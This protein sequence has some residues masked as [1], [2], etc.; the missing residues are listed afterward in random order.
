MSEGRPGLMAAYLIRG[1]ASLGVWLD[2]CRASLPR[3]LT[4]AATLVL[5]SHR[6][7]HRLR[8]TACL[9]GQPGLLAGVRM[10]RPEELAHEILLRAG[11]ETD[12][13]LPKLRVV[14]LRGLLGGGVPLVYLTPLPDVRSYAE[15]IGRTIGDL[16][17]A[18][19]SPADLRAGA[20]AASAGITEDPV[21]SDRLRDI[22]ALWEAADRQLL[23]EDPRPR[24]PAGLLLAAAAELEREPAVAAPFG[25][26]FTLLPLQPTSG[27]LRFVAS[28][29]PRA[30]GLLAGRPERDS[31]RKLRDA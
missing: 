25:D 9:R 6:L 30:V 7:A 8:R 20:D 13:A 14:A 21:L 11:V 27:L 24:S 15:A 3:R 16:E 22:A 28:L 2:A 5:P 4:R 10:R 1:S 29:R 26:V 31:W 23:G 17:A 12:P 19:L 18:G